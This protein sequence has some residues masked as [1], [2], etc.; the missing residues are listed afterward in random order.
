MRSKKDINNRNSLRIENQEQV[1]SLLRQYA[2]LSIVAMA[3]KLGLSFPAVSNIVDE[4]L[5]NGVLS[6]SKEKPEKGKKGRKPLSFSLNDQAGVTAAIDLSSSN[7]VIALFDL[8]DKLI[9]EDGV[10]N[11]EFI[12]RKHFERIAE[13]IPSLLKRPEAEGRKLLGIAIASP[14]MINSR[15]GDY[16]MAYRVKDYAQFNPQNYYSNLFNVPTKLYNDVRVGALAEKIFGAVPQDMRNFLYMHIGS[17]SGLALFL[18]G[19]LYAGINGYSGEISVYNPVDDLSKSC[20]HNKLYSLRRLYAKI[21]EE[22]N[23]SRKELDLGQLLAWQREK[24]PIA[25]RC[26]EESAKHNALA[27]IGYADL[28][29]LEGVILEGPIVALGEEYRSL[30]LRYINLYDA[31]EVRVRL[32]FSSLQQNNNLLGA[33]YLA[34]TLHFSKVIGEITKKRLAR[35]ESALPSSEIEEACHFFK[36]Y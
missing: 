2:S 16:A 25:M 29:D 9:C 10:P 19:K 3:E 20:R 6:V 5:S 34:N 1:V 21:A 22:K 13:I 23:L 24:D 8:N 27:I 14:G 4:L 18:N 36:D 28:L 30:L 33:A 32:L 12:E 7:L 15:T 26:I 35:D 11:V 17:N 31:H